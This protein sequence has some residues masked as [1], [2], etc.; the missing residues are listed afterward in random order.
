[1]ATIDL[2][3]TTGFLQDTKNFAN[4]DENVGALSLQEYQ[5]R[6]LV[7]IN[8][9]EGYARNEANFGPI[10]SFRYLNDGRLFV[11]T[12][13]WELYFKSLTFQSI[14]INGSSITEMAWYN[15]QNTDYFYYKGNMKF[16]GM[17]LISAMKDGSE[18]TSVGGVFKTQI[19]GYSNVTF[20]F[21]GNIVSNGYSFSGVVDR[22]VESLQ[23]LT[24]GALL[25]TGWEGGKTTPLALIWQVEK[26]LNFDR[27]TLLIMEKQ[28][29]MKL[30]LQI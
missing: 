30:S 7:A 28:F 10:Y 23:N 27:N 8:A 25:V 3:N 17:P 2:Y 15:K 14:D 4:F 24:T 9:Q 13:K 26:L 19:P 12:N 22:Y 16:E 20:E 21:Q 11:E 29:R 5:N 1:M 6:I 18:I